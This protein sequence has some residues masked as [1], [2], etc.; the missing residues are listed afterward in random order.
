[1]RGLILSGPLAGFPKLLERLSIR[2]DRFKKT[3]NHYFSLVR[4]GMYGSAILDSM[5]FPAELYSHDWPAP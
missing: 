5:I 4:K 1:M 2:F 3:E